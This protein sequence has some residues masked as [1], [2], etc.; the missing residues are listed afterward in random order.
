MPPIWNGFIEFLDGDLSTPD[1]DYFTWVLSID[2]PNDTNENGIPD[3][4]DDPSTTPVDPASLRL[5]YEAGNISLTISGA[6]GRLHEIQATAALDPPE[7][8]TVDS[9]TLVSDPQIVE[10]PGPASGQLFWRVR[11]P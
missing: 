4:S 8:T 9:L 2:D 3:F 1:E 11:V 6:V 5:D 10:L 7:W